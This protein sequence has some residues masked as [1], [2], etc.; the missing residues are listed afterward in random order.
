VNALHEQF[1]IEARELIHQAIDDLIAMERDGFTPERVDRAFRAFHTLKGSAGVVALP[2]MTLALHAAEDLLAAINAGR[3]SASTAAVDQAL[4]CLDKVSAW[5]DDFEDFASLPP[6]AGDD[7]RRIAER[8]RALLS[9]PTSKGAAPAV[10]GTA[11]LAGALPEWAQALIRAE[12]AAIARDR[13]PHRL[14]AV[15]YEPHAGCFF[16]GDDPI[17]LMRQIPGVL[18]VC[19]EARAPWPPLADLDPF[20]CNLR[21]LA[22]CGADGAAISNIFRLAPDQVRIVEVP[23]DALPRV[24]SLK[25]ADGDMSALV[26]AVIAEQRQVLQI[27]GAPEDFVGRVGAAARAAANALR[28]GKRADLAAGVE[29]A[30]ATALA[31]GSAAPLVSALGAIVERPDV[32]ITAVHAPAVGPSAAPAEESEHGARRSLRVDEAKIDALINLAGELIVRKNGFAHLTKWA[33]VT[34]DTDFG[35][36]LR[37]EHDALERL[38]GELHAAILQLRMVSVAQVFRSFPRLVRDMALQLDKKVELV[39]RGEITE[40]DKTIVDR[41]FEPLLHLVRNALDH[42][43]ET[44]EQRRAAGKPETA[45]ITMQ[46]TRSGDRFVVEV[47]DDGRGIDPATVRRRARERNLMALDELA[48]LRDEQVLDLIF[49]TGFSTAIEVSEISGRGVGMDVVRAT[50]AQMGGHVS[51]SSHV[52]V[53]TTVRLDLPINIA[54]SGIMVVEAGQ[55]V[56]GIALDAVLETVRL[57]PDRIIQIK[58]NAGFVLRDRIVPIRSLAEAMNLPALPTDAHETR[59]LIVTEVDGR[60][61][62]LEVD[63][64]R[65]RLQVVLKPMQ[66]L[67]SSARG[68]SGTTLLGNGEVLLVLDLREI[69]P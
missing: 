24:P 7:A 53:G 20:A 4:A 48:A 6:D 23:L 1:V 28:H 52:G 34:T 12:G 56:F 55:Q 14:C 59:L 13:L 33:E 27:A 54:L 62:A 17:Q 19:I 60:I 38:G 39:T 67:L 9:A 2:A 45:V 29:R 41:L 3:L 22:I 16:D 68:Y 47:I 32:A 49:S 66:G 61:V 35:R 15:R 10:G 46:A 50:A 42:G 64:I 26:R 36:A 57:T 11:E 51:V 5:V 63:A 25:A 21:L 58:S 43:I 40:S 44:S 8:L 30:Q 18:T 65:E 31:Q 37:R 69:L